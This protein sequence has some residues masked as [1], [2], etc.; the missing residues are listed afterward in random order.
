MIQGARLSRLSRLAM[1]G[2]SNTLHLAHATRLCQGYP[3]NDHQR[4]KGKEGR[5]INA[6]IWLSVVLNQVASAFLEGK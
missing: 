3:D 1:R 4:D 6:R 5:E 2:A